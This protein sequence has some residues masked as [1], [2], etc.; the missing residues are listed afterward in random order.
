[1][2][3]IGKVARAAGLRASAIRFYESHG[4]LPKPVR[5]PNGYR[6]YGQETVALLGF[7]RRAEE[8]GITLRDIGRLLALAGQGRRPCCEVKE[9]A[10]RYIRE[11]DLKLNE[12]TRLRSQL[13]SLRRKRPAATGLNAI[14]P[15]IQES[16]ATPTCASPSRS[17]RGRTPNLRSPRSAAHSIAPGR[18]A[19]PRW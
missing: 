5:L 11:I 2:L 13:Q 19:A 8:L 10:R 17:I 1:M 15:L 16:E 9:L 3:T 18:A 6:T 4:I 7:V 14:C 12:L